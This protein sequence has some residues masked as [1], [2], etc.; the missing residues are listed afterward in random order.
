MARC[1]AFRTPGLIPLESF[2]TFGVNVKPLTNTPFGYFG[3]GLKYAIA[4]LLRSGCR[5]VL[6]R[7]DERYE[8]YVTNQDFR[9]REFSF[10]RMKRQRGILGR[11]SYSKLPFTLELGKNW[12]LWQAF[13]ELE[14]NTRD[15]GGHTELMESRDGEA[16]TLHPLGTT[17]IMVFGDKFVD[18]FFDMDRHF[19]PDGETIRTDEDIQVIDRVSRHVYYR[20]VRIMDLKE[21]AE[22]TYNILRSVDLTEDRTAKYPYIVEQI[23]AEHWLNSEDEDLVPRV[24]HTH[25]WES[26]GLSYGYAYS[27]PSPT[28][29]TSALTSTNA[30]VREYVK[31]K[32]PSVPATVTLQIVVPRPEVSPNELSDVARGVA[33]LLDLDKVTVRNMTDGDEAVFEQELYYN[34]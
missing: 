2:T 27:A 14:T 9:G 11:F 31:Q 15:E 30:S 22:F 13:R 10:V 19:L 34:V 18:E 8:F 28:F 16:Q 17:T 29:A 32:D 20:G 7:G 21:E 24:L 6:W 3:T 12:E 25:R 33:E 5:V 4:V 26:R 1:V 23:I